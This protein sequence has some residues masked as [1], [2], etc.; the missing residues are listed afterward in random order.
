MPELCFKSV[1]HNT[2]SVS[3]FR[4][5]CFFG[6]TRSRRMTNLFLL[7]EGCLLRKLS[8]CELIS[9]PL[10]ILTTV[11]C[12]GTCNA[13]QILCDVLVEWMKFPNLIKRKGKRKK[14]PTNME[15]LRCWACS[16]CSSYK[17]S[18]ARKYKLIELMCI[19][20]SCSSHPIHFFCHQ[21]R[22]I[23]SPSLF[24]NLSVFLFISKL[25][26]GY[27]TSIWKTFLINHFVV[28]FIYRL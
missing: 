4:S 27:N 19:E 1:L 17:T 26:R 2:I 24:H 16:T 6:G 10:V 28:Q 13:V 25:F 8:R 14:N 22:S 15:L 20:S 11:R 7:Q 12:A 18:F 9:I 5:S 21:I 3:S 23:F